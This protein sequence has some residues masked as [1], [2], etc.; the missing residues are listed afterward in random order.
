[1]NNPAYTYTVSILGDGTRIWRLNEQKHRHDGPAVEWCDG[2]KEWWIDGELHR[3]DGP[4]KEHHDGRKEWWIKGK[5]HRE[6]GPAIVD[7][8]FQAE[9]NSAYL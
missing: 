4:A 5:L 2:T 3:T 7:T 1:M 9:R 6:D 8:L